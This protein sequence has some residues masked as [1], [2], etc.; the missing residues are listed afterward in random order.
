MSQVGDQVEVLTGHGTT[1]ATI[2][3][4]NN[5]GTV[6]LHVPGGLIS[7]DRV[8]TDFTAEASIVYRIIPQSEANNGSR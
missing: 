4:R 2:I 5:D 1:P 3:A 7:T 8:A 6:T